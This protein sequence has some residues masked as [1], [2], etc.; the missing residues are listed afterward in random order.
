MMHNIRYSVNKATENINELV[1]C[2]I[3]K[4]GVIAVPTDTLYGL[5]CLSSNIEA[6]NR[7]YQI[8][9]RDEKKPLAISLS[10][11]SDVPKWTDLSLNESELS[12]FFPG[13]CT[14]IF[15]R[16]TLLSSCL[17]P[18]Q[19]DVG[20][21]VPNHP[22]IRLL[23]SILS[24][25]GHFPIALTSANRSSEPSCTTVEQFQDLWPLLDF[26]VDSGPVGNSIMGSTV[27]D[28]TE[29]GIYKI[30][31]E[32]ENLTDYCDKLERKLQWIRR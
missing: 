8:K 1:D 29:H 17:N 14:L 27:I 30:I 15:K 9:G 18:E 28:L 7:L 21:R 25:L 3:N 22:F 6:I 13:P 31:R 10:D 2:L 24:R 32:G 4:N 16:N 26:V 19:N 23:S 12:N 20:V 11:I 5:C